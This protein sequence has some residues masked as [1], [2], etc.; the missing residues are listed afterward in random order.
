M[1]RWAGNWREVVVVRSVEA[2]EPEVVSTRPSAVAMNVV[3]VIC[4][5]VF[6]FEAFAERPQQDLIDVEGKQGCEG[7]AFPSQAK[8]GSSQ[9]ASKDESSL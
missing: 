7:C 6:R 5:S 4:D 3:V 1:V 9:E 8:R 2:H